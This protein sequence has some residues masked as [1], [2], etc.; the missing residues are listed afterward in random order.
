[1]SRDTYKLG[2]KESVHV[3]S[4]GIVA[5][6]M[7]HRRMETMMAIVDESFSAK[8][9]AGRHQFH[10]SIFQH[11]V[12]HPFVFFWQNGARRINDV[13]ARCAL[14]TQAIDGREQKFALQIVAALNVHFGFGRF[15]AGILGNDASSRARCIDQNTIE[16]THYAL[17]FGSVFATDDRVH[18]AQSMEVANDGFDAILVRIVR[19]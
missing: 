11:I 1:M 19:E 16:A 18:D 17:E 6:R 10:I 7:L 9:E 13:A 8:I 2:H 12:D 14:C 15:H 3:V 4:V 5:A